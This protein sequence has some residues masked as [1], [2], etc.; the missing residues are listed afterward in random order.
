MKKY[1]SL[2]LIVLLLVSVTLTGCGGSSGDGADVVDQE[3]HTIKTAA[4]IDAN[5]PMGKMYLEFERMVEERSAGRIQVE[6]FLNGE[7]AAANREQLEMARQGTIQWQTVPSFEYYAQNTELSEFLL[8][9]LPF[10]FDDFTSFYEFTDSDLMKEFYKEGEDALGVYLYPG[11]SLGWVNIAANT[12]APITS[13]QD[14]KGLKIRTS[15][16]DIY[17]KMVASWGASPTSIEWH[18][19]YTALQQGAL[20]GLTTAT[21]LFV[22]SKQVE[23]LDHFANINVIP[24]NH[25]VCINKEW[26]D[27]LPEDLQTIVDDCTYEAI[28]KGRGYFEEAEVAALDYIAEVSQ[29]TELTPEQRQ[30]WVTPTLPIWEENADMIGRDFYDKALAQLGKK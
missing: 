12:K 20:D 6:V 3:T 24:F 29:L 18:E 13:P 2:I 22:T 9:D 19:S 10:L 7:L 17:Q 5:D 26:F 30:E 16:S 8:F 21:N 28:E 14:I 23:V 4:S 15:L 11:V 27:S 1:I 25:F